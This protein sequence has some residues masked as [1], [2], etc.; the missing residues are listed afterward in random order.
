MATILDREHDRAATA[1]ESP[2]RTS[3]VLVGALT[4]SLLALAVAWNARRDAGTETAPLV[5]ASSTAPAIREEVRA[6]SAPRAATPARTEAR[7]DRAPRPL[8]GNP[9]P[10]YPRA[11][12]RNGSEGNVVLNIVVGTDGLPMDVQVVERGGTRDR[13]FDRAAVEAARQWRFEPA[14]RD[15][16]AVPSTV[17]LPIEFRR[18]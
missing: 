18:S 3:P 2:R 8:A 7:I 5:D 16:E 4:V 13:A 11:A 15:G 10:S 1:G 9:V 6:P 12:L 17:R 14:L